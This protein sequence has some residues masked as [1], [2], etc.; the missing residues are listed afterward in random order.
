MAK[1]HRRLEREKIVQDNFKG[2]D[3]MMNQKEIVEKFGI[4]KSTLSEM[5]SDMKKDP[6]EVEV[7]GLTALDA[8][9]DPDD[10]REKWKKRVE[11]EKVKKVKRYSQRIRFPENLPCGLWWSSDWHLGSPYADVVLLEE[12]IELVNKTPGMYAALAGDYHEAC[13]GRMSFTGNEIPTTFAEELIGLDMYVGMLA[14]KLILMTAGNHD[15]GRAAKAIGLDHIALMM[16]GTG[17][18]YDRDEIRFKLECGDASW[19]V[20]ARHR[21]KGHSKY[22]PTHGQENAALF[23]DYDFDL[24]VGG[25]LHNGTLLREFWNG[26]RQRKGLVVQ[27]GTYK[28]ADSFAKEI[29]FND[30]PPDPTGAIVFFPDGR[31]FASADIETAV[32]FLAFARKRMAA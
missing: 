8:M 23:G 26:K 9:P 4:P 28:M 18:L 1:I 29:G 10:V 7:V 13:I 30:S 15:A 22:N 12:H 17:C 27:L 14:E 25:H 19:N 20:E 32:E 31:M 3:G 5:I 24:A 6:V 21:W 16:R 2:F 11:Q